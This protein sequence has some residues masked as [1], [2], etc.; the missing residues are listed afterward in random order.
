MKNKDFTILVADDNTENLRL[1]STILLSEGYK[2]ALV[3][4]GD[5]VMKIIDENK[6]DLILLDILM[7]GAMDGFQVCRNLK[8]NPRTQDIPVIFLSSR[9]ETDDILEGFNIG[10]ADFIS[11]P[12]SR[13]ELLAR[14][15][16]HLKQ[17]FI[18]DELNT[19]IKYLEHSRADFMKWLHSLANSIESRSS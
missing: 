7:P 17:K 8:K 1:V 5:E 19:R 16:N 12:F 2:L 18:I 6:I 13:Q 9:R 11:K 10:G 15:N 3:H 4:D 14:V